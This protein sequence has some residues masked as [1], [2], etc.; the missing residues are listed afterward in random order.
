MPELGI[1]YDSP[2]FRR[3]LAYADNAQ[4]A[5]HSLN[6]ANGQAKRPRGKSMSAT[7]PN[8]I[9]TDTVRPDWAKKLSD[10]RSHQ[11]RRS[12]AATALHT[13]AYMMNDRGSGF[14][15]LGRRRRT[16]FVV[17]GSSARPE[18]MN[19]LH[20]EHLMAVLEN[21]E[22][23][24]RDRRG[25]SNSSD[26]PPHRGSSRANRPEDLEELMMMEAIRLSLQAEEERKKKEEKEAEKERK[27]EEK[28]RAKE[29]KKA[30]KAA[31]KTG[32]SSYSSS[33][34]NSQY[35]SHGSGSADA[36]QSPP[37]TKGKGRAASSPAAS[38][39]SRGYQPGG[40]TP[41]DE[42][43]STINQDAANQQRHDESR[44]H[45]EQTRADLSNERLGAHDA[46]PHTSSYTS[47]DSAQGESRDH[48]ESEAAS[49]AGFQLPAIPKTEDYEG[50]PENMFNFSS[51]NEMIDREHS[52]DSHPSAAD[53]TRS[54]DTSYASTTE[55]PGYHPGNGTAQG[56]RDDVSSKHGGNVEVVGR[57]Q[58][59]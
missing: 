41:I 59:T 46:M 55:P 13:A 36:S 56:R 44:Q 14:P 31:R 45:L 28:K 54:R 26:L 42:P 39:R 7:D 16:N 23:T 34:N 38:A 17:E 2:P 10:A 48:A 24:R 29:Q 15:G 47:L 33:R 52:E 1:T 51:L 11:A 3:G 35:F 12:A 30:D 22:S 40:F 57:T 18:Q 5:A 4:S 6:V 21:Q 49:T 19:P 8:V 43:T 32:T 58:E 37:E 53:D 9:T 50:A 20:L 27:K 25:N